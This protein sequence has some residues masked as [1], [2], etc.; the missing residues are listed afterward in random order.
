MRLENLQEVQTLKNELMDLEK[1]A[2]FAER[3]NPMKIQFSDPIDGSPRGTA[4]QVSNK[5]GEDM[6]KALKHLILIE[7]RRLRLQICDQLDAL[8]VEPCLSTTE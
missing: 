1:I 3:G 2:N 6:Q 5:C 7:V 8:G 4:L